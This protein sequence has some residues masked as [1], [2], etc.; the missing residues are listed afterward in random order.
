MAAACLHFVILVL[1]ARYLGVE[2]YG[3]LSYV[4][5]FVG[6]FEF[7]ANA[8]LGQILVREIAVR[9]EG[10][11]RVVG[12]TKSLMWALSL[13]TFAAIVVAVH[14]IGATP[15]IRL[16]MYLAAGG[17][18]AVIHAAAY[19]AVFRAFEEME[20]NAAAFVVEKV[21]FLV[22]VAAG[23]RLDGGLLAMCGAMF[24]AEVLLCAYY[25]VVLW[26][27]HFRPRVYVDFRQWWVLLAESLPLGVSAI[28]RRISWQA[29]ILILAT[30]GMTA[31]VG[32]F[33][34]GHRL[35]QSLNLVPLTVAQVTF[36]A[37][38]RLARG[39]PEDL[40]T[41]LER[42]VKL[43]LL[44]SFASAVTLAAAADRVVDV[45]YGSAF[46]PA[47]IPLAVMGVSLLF[48]FPSSLFMFIFTAMGIQRIF[49]LAA[50]ASLA[51]K[52]AVDV[53][54]IPFLG[55]IGASLGMLAGEAVLCVTA[56]AVLASRTLRVPWVRLAWRPGLAALAM[57]TVLW[58]VRGTGLVLFVAGV[59]L[60]GAL[61]AS[62]LLLLRAISPGEIAVI[63][64][65]IRPHLRS[66]SS[67]TE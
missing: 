40:R 19:S 12:V 21:A 1:I 33:S 35:I 66:V 37:F 36:P 54:L 16:A 4:L 7:V 41:A 9:A 47:A 34:A 60:G 28:V 15:E 58:A 46:A 8:G 27:R 10:V 17:V 25:F 3:Q 48:L 55:H 13:L 26:R 6:V 59:L 18:I 61:Y 30:F 29:D 63:R 24:F 53:A 49:T 52:V 5:A 22:L 67:Q 23:I 50:L 38:S 43:I 11:R 51:V 32:Y 65:T 62:I 56:S 31:A 2:R 57:G 42:A 44:L 45:L 39:T 14:L 64:S 20:V